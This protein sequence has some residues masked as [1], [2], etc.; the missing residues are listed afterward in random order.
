MGVLDK[1]FPEA[2]KA[3][4]TAQ[5]EKPATPA[6]AKEEYR[7]FSAPVPDPQIRLIIYRK[8]NACLMPRYDVLY[9]VFFNECGTEL[10]LVFAHQLLM[11]RGQKLTEIV[12]ALRTNGVEWIRE[13]DSRIHQP[14]VGDACIVTAIE[15]KAARP[16]PEMFDSIDRP[17]AEK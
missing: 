10:G 4:A 6:P 8:K 7:A 14:V 2:A 12:G 5:Q 1:Y 11:L 15:V 3:P 9:D 13:Y 17:P 16:M